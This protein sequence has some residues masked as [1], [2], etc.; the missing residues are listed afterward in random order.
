MRDKD[1][2]AIGHY[3]YINR[4]YIISDDLFL[5]ISFSYKRCLTLVISNMIFMVLIG[6]IV[7]TVSSIARISHLLRTIWPR[8]QRDSLTPFRDSF[9]YRKRQDTE[10]G[11]AL[12]I[13]RYGATRAVVQNLTHCV[14]NLLCSSLSLWNIFRARNIIVVCIL[15]IRYKSSFDAYQRIMSTIDEERKVKCH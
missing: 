2:Y 13:S 15:I 8:L 3:F 7:V 5:Y 10:N 11:N 4:I 9:L 14:K 1:I 6:I 12:V